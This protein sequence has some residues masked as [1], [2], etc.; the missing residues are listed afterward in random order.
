MVETN[1]N[2]PLVTITGVTGYLGSQVLNEFLMLEGKGM[3]RIRATVRDRNNQA[4]LAPLRKAFGDMFQSIEFVNADLTDPDS[5][6]R[7]SQGSKYVVHT[8]SPV[9][10]NTRNPDTFI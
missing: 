4:K 1:A 6:D 9:G 2:L 5:L 10:I 8:A 3:F 7:A